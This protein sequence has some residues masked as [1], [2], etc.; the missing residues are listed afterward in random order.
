[1]K[2]GW[3]KAFFP[4][5]LAVP[6][7][8]FAAGEAT[9]LNA[10]AW[11]AQKITGGIIAADPAHLPTTAERI[12][13]VNARLAAIALARLQGKESDALTLFDGCGSYCEKFGNGE[14]WK[15]VKAWGCAK[16]RDT[17]VCPGKTKAQK[18]P[19]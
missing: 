19:H 18:P 13:W 7:P 17:S 14:E 8:L 11:D 3:F 10:S 1:M 4:L 9:Y 15:A 12:E 6:A 16:K 2:K 5:V